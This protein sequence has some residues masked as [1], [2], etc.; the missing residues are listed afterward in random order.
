MSNL[1]SIS[2][3]SVAEEILDQ[4]PKGA[5]LTVKWGNRLNVMTIGWGTLGFVWSRSVMVVPVRNTRYTYG[6]IQHAPDFTVSVPFPGQF[7][8]EIALCG[9]QSGRNVDKIAKCGFQTR[10][11]E[12]VNTP[13]LDIPGI[14]LECRTLLRTPID[15]NL[16]NAELGSLYAEEDYHTF[17]YGE[18][19]AAVKQS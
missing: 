2:P 14:H 1:A 13:V 11:A 3:V 10:D 4:L 8:P 5:L 9:T 6:L 17:Y 12:Q 15:P 19:V 16:M 7:K 18:I